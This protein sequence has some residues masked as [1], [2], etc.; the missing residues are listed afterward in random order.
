[1]WLLLAVPLLLV[2]IVI[3]L[4]L[5]TA[6]VFVTVAREVPWVLILLG[7]WIIWR[8]NRPHRQHRRRAWRHETGPIIEHDAP[9]PVQKSS[10]QALAPQ[11]P[12]RELPIDVQVMVEQ[13][14]RKADVLQGYAD[15]FPPMSQDLHIVRQTTADYLP[16]T[17]AAYLA[18]PSD[19]DPFDITTNEQ[20]LQELRSQLRILDSKLDEIAQDLQREDMER[21]LA[22]RR[23]LEERFRPRAMG[24]PPTRDAA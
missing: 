2:L 6:A 12:R 9:A 20:A 10:P 24:D 7:A 13:I 23:F 17:V 8:S 11:R 19:D 22:N 16:R 5:G 21:L 18:L 14:T 3:S 1:M 15:R 4:I